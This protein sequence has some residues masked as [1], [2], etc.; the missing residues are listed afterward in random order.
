MNAGLG[1]FSKNFLMLAW[2]TNLIAKSVQL[3]FLEMLKQRQDFV[4]LRCDI[5][6]FMVTF[7]V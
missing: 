7:T 1:S 3:V 5:T 6:N 4:R 2:K